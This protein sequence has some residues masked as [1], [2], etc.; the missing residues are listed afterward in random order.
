MHKEQNENPKDALISV[1]IPV[2]NVKAYLAR[3]VNSV[4]TQTYPHLEIFLVDDG[5]TDGSGELC[6]SLASGDERIRVIHR[7]NGGLSVARNTALDMAQGDFIAFVDGDDFI[8]P[9]MYR[10]MLS[11]QRKTG[12]DM[13]TVPFERVPQDADPEAF[14]LTEAD[15]EVEVVCECMN[16]QEILR[17]M[18]KRDAQ[19]VV[20]WNKLFCRKVLDS[21]RF[22]EGRLHE[23]FHV[24]HRELWNCDCIAQ[25]N[26][27]PYYYAEREG[28][29][30]RR[31]SRSSMND[32]LEGHVDSILFFRENEPALSCVAEAGMTEHMKWRFSELAAQGAKDDCLWFA[33]LCKEKADQ[34]NIAYSDP[35]MK[36]MLESPRK[37]YGK[38]RVKMKIKRMLLLRTST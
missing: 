28:S 8:H 29:I 23:D 7:E 25:L 27:P 13:V 12:A 9:D 16:R 34:L 11:A 10:C 2:Y 20:Q 35:E 31:P 4:M 18:L 32:L 1:I 37:Y 38:L 26:L 5:S 30:S 3:C 15:E 19:T 21:I 24:I 22:P 6:D 33:A 14:C 17:T 36:D